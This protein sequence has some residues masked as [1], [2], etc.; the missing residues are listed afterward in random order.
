MHDDSAAIL[1][2]IK[3]IRTI[4]ISF[5]LSLSLSLSLA[6][7]PSLFHI[8]TMPWH[9]FGLPGNGYWGYIFPTPPPP[10]PPNV[11]PRQMINRVVNQRYG[12]NSKPGGSKAVSSKGKGVKGKDKGVKCMGKDKVFEH[13]HTDDMNGVDMVCQQD[14]FDQNC[15][16]YDKDG[17]KMCWSVKIQ[18]VD[19]DNTELTEAQEKCPGGY[20]EFVH[21]ARYP[22]EHEV[23]V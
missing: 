11:T 23:R 1:A 4:G 7:A 18:K 9:Y 12:M 15:I 5:S 2:Q 17:K 13:D 8:D 10:P 22:K 14:Y 16:G 6:R 3:N 21:C 20:K 19:M